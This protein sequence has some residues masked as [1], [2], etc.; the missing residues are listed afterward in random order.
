MVN[1]QGYLLRGDCRARAGTAVAAC[2][3]EHNSLHSQRISVNLCAGANGKLAVAVEQSQE[4]P[5]SADADESYTVIDGF[6][7]VA[8]FF[9]VRSALES[10]GSLADR[11]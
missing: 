6:K 11:G 4:F 10:N 1:T 7:G 2:F 3:I 8:G 9:V 5:L